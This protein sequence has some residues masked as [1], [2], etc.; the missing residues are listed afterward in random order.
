[1]G[2][3]QFQ[4][5]KNQTRTG[6]ELGSNYFSNEPDPEPKVPHKSQEPPNTG[7]YII[8]I[9]DIETDIKLV[10][11]WYITFGGPYQTGRLLAT[12]IYTSADDNTMCRPPSI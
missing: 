5:L 10:Q 12:N 8:N 2:W 3:F 1:M 11:G 9:R 6:T 4:S 7:I